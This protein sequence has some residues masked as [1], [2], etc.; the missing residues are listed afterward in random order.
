MVFHAGT[1]REGGSW[2]I[3]AG[4]AAYVVA[5]AP[6]RDEA[7]RAAYAAIETLGGHGWRCRTDIAA[8]VATP[9]AGARGG[10]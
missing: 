1:R 9:A 7:R 8:A 10:A 6:Q 2:G 4:R 3:A 5:V